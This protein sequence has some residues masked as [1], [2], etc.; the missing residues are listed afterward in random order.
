MPK[1]KPVKPLIKMET[2]Y[3]KA[4]NEG[5]LSPL[6]QKTLDRLATVPKLN[7]A[8]RNAI[9]T[10]FESVMGVSDFG[11]GVATDAMDNLRLMHR[12]RMIDNFQKALGVDITPMMS[13]L[14][15][16]PIME[17][18]IADNAK[19]IKSIPA[20]MLPKMMGEFEKIFAEGFDQEKLL[21]IINKRFKVGGS[22]AKLIARDQTSK[23]IGQLTEARQVG[24]G[25]DSYIWITMD[26]ESV[27]G[28]PGGEFPDGNEIHMDHFSRNG[29]E[30]FW[31]NPPPDGHPGQ[32]INC[33]CVAQAVIRLNRGGL[34]AN[35]DHA[36]ILRAKDRKTL[37][38]KT[39]ICNI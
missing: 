22:R 1:I 36:V 14:R 35:L 9:A 27:V 5:V 21:K 20:G 10:E 15:I 3:A 2:A 29:I 16:R 12:Q 31:N 30:F 11:L 13:D 17:K 24:M 8:W 39:D 18:A 33:R 7:T 28:N 38:G 23:I 32:A 4:I 25:I 19:L 6:L 34:E 37:S 26:D